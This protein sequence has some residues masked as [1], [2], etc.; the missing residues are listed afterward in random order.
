MTQSTPKQKKSFS[1][2]RFIKG[3]WN[4]RVV[5]L[6]RWW[7]VV[8]FIIT[9]VSIAGGMYLEYLGISDFWVNVLA[10]IPGIFV[11]FIIG[12]FILNK[13]EEDKWAD[14]RE[15]LLDSLLTRLDE[16]LLSLAGMIR[17]NYS[18][19]YN[20]PLINSFFPEQTQESHMLWVE[21]KINFLLKAPK[22]ID[23]YEDT[24][25]LSNHLY[26]CITKYDYHL[27][28]YL[29]PQL[30][31]SSIPQ[32]LSNELIKFSELIHRIHRGMKVQEFISPTLF[33]AFILNIQEIYK[34][35]KGVLKKDWDTLNL[36]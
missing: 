7:I 10:G 1:L 35:S 20:F 32:D 6:F 8:S 18:D 4:R 27:V 17:F 12:I 15:F 2:I 30:L 25:T 14:A 28:N 24:L 33:E 26:G 3:L 19:K 5:K 36:Q 11:A 13:Y 21:D 22:Q 16:L 29:V 9:L 23:K 34:L 31:K